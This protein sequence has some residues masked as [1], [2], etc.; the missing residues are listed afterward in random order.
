MSRGNRAGSIAAFAVGAWVCVAAASAATP[1]L[2]YQNGFESADPCAWSASEP[3]A[4]CDPEMVFVP[5][6]QFAMGSTQGDADELPIHTVYVDAYWID[7]FEVTVDAWNACVSAGGC[8]GSNGSSSC[9]VNRP[10]R[11]SHPYNCATWTQAHN[12]CAWAGKRLPT[13]AEWERAARGT[14]A[15][16]YPWGETEPTCDYAVIWDSALGTFGCGVN[17]TQ[18]VGSRAAGS[19]ASGALDMTGNVWEWVNDW[20]AADYY[21]NSPATNPAGPATGTLRVLRGGSWYESGPGDLRAAFR[22]AKSPTQS[23]VNN[24]FRCALSA[25]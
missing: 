3:A 4:D 25:P 11:G 6:A 23:F 15:A 12:Y 10:D 13:E 20:Y 1:V 7:R 9:N 8:G 14:T 19:S 16:T 22:N 17:H 5:A 24:G 21:A 18:P 2:V